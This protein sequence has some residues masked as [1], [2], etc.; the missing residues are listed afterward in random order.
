MGEVTRQPGMSRSTLAAKVCEWI[1]WR[2][3]LGKPQLASARK[4]LGRL[5]RCG[6]IHLPALSAASHVG[7]G[8]TVRAPSAPP[9]LTLVQVHGELGALGTVELVVVDSP[10]HRVVYSQLMQHHPLGEQRLCGAQMRYLFRCAQG[11]LGACAFQSASFALQARDRWIGWSENMR[12]G[13]LAR[14][15]CNA[16]FLI[17]PSVQ[18]PHLASHLLGLL[19]RVLPDQWEERYGV[20]PLLL[21]TYVHPDFEGTCY[22]AAGWSCVGHSAGRRDGVPKAVW[23]RELE[24]DAR[25]ALRQGPALVPRERPDNAQRWA[26]AEFGALGVW[27]ARLK[28]R[29]VDLAEDFFGHAQARSVTRRCAE[30]A[31]TVAAYRFFR[32]PKISMHTLL[33]AHREAAIERMRAHPV[34]LVPQDTTSLNYSAHPGTEGLGP[35]GTKL[36]GGPIGLML[37]NSHAFTPQGVPL[38]VVSADCWARDPDEHAQRRPQDARESRKWLDAYQVLQE[39]APRVPETCLVSIGDRE[40]DLFELF[41]LAR[42]PNSPRLLVRACQGRR[43]QVSTEA[44]RLP[45]WPHMQALPVAGYTSVNIPRRG[46]HKART[47]LLSVRFGPVTIEAPK[48]KAG[49]ACTTDAPIELWAVHLHEEDPPAGV[50]AVQW[51]L[52]TNVPTTSLD[53]ALE[54]ARWYAAR[55]GIEVFHRTLKTGCQL[56]DRQLGYAVRLENCLAIDMVVAWR[57]YYLTMLGRMDPQAPCTVFFRDPE[58]KALYSW[59]HHTTQIPATAPTLRDATRWIAIKGGFQGRKSDGHPGAEV[60]WHGLQKLD[61]AIEMYLLYRPGELGAMRDEY[62]PGYLRPEPD[63]S[64]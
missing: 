57:I 35:I 31:K 17:L 27:D 21:E 45:L 34:V 15:V 63:D 48:D 23:V 53:D 1:G 4:A 5:D 9:P 7:R 59:Y 28:R 3:A 49:A 61:V 18:V 26:E 25:Q 29:A 55:W 10:E 24:S 43:R 16:R 58:W 46:Q 42:D 13:N 36:E 52:L 50:E 11:W 47:A 30:R 20:R 19:A 38:G 32:N 54:R 37:H 2:N 51:M 64:S 8:S 6:A 39:I 14:V 62:P 60:M 41:A 40:A 33:E 12:R 56:E 22:K 44:G